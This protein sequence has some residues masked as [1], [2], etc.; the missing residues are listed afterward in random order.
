MSYN[1]VI[2]LAG[3][4]GAGCSSLAEDLTRII[5]DLP[6]C[7][8]EKIHVASI[9]NNLSG[10]NIA[11]ELTASDRRRKLQRAGTELRLKD[12]D[13]VGN[14]IVTE[15][16]KRGLELES[17]KKLLNKDI[18]FF[19][20]DSL[21]NFHELKILKNTYLNEFF[22]L[23]VH[24]NKESRWRRMKDYKS[25]LD[26]ERVDF[27]ECDSIDG[28]EKGVKLEVGDAGQQVGRL[29]AFADYYIVN[30]ENRQKLQEEAERFID[31]LLGDS[32]NQ[33]TFHE[34]SMHLAFS[35]SNRSYCLS[36]QVGAAIVDKK[37]NILGIGFNDVPKA[38]GGLYTQEDEND[39]RCY[40]VGDRR[41]INDT[42]KEER[43]NE[44]AEQFHKLYPTIEKKE[45]Y[46]II[47]SSSFKQATEYCR[48]VHAEMEALLSLCRSYGNSSLG[49]IMYVTTYPCHNCTKHILCAGISKVVYIEPYPKS[50][51]EELHSDAIDVA[52]IDEN[53]S[54]KLLFIPYRGVS[55][56]RYQDFFEM[57]EDRKDK[58]GKYIFK[59]KEEKVKA[60]RFCFNLINRFR[61]EE[62]ID[63]ISAKELIIS[64]WCAKFIEDNLESGEEDGKISFAEK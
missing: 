23:F 61:N 45:A 7:V 62:K 9:I 25:W 51:A 28:D 15:I 20:V 24:A 52:P 8:V 35:A 39:K 63:S 29:S 64:A 10:L 54:N 46:K 57:R 11:G 33:P 38:G 21:K 17:E 53:F 49:A 37:G 19:I 41:C 27:E 16:Y 4:Y 50:L 14:F 32:K 31:L 43:F 44:I 59:G 56:K 34:R 2:G 12:P 60:P 47:S 55:P 36:K 5:K 48:A 6:N 40:M 22:F 18:V 42:N 30:N 13:L 26:K 58:D 1:I 3:P